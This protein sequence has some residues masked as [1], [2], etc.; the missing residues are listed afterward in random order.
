MTNSTS[1]LAR[2]SEADAIWRAEAAISSAPRSEAE[3]PVLATGHFP[4]SVVIVGRAGTGTGRRE[5]G[6]PASAFASRNPHL[7][8]HVC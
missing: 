2:H 3:S 4:V 8:P 5:T 1:V 7:V 6:H